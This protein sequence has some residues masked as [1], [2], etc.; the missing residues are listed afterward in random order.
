MRDELQGGLHYVRHHG[1]LVALIVLAAATTF[2]GFAVLTF[3]PVFAQSV[4]H[5]GRQHLQPPDGVFRRRLDRRRAHRRVAR[6]SS[7]GWG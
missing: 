2:L 6:A 3:L 4:F 1:S 7:S 5:A